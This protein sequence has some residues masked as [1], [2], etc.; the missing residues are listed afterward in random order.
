MDVV[1][2][3]KRGEKVTAQK[4]LPDKDKCLVKSVFPTVSNWF[5]WQIYFK[6]I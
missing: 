5:V 4:Y 6:Y 2:R 3:G 1:G